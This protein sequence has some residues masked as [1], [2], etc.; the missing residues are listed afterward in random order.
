VLRLA[1]AGV[2]WWDTDELEPAEIKTV[3]EHVD[4]SHGL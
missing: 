4:R 1:S 3:D 2:E